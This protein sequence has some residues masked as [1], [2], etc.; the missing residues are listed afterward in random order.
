M[1]SAKQN[2]SIARKERLKGELQGL[3]ASLAGVSDSE[4]D[5]NVSFMELGLDSLFLTQACQSLQKKYSQRITFR[6]LMGDLSSIHAL[7]IFLDGKLPV[8]TAPAA[9]LAPSDA[10]VTQPAAARSVAGAEAERGLAGDALLER[11]VNQQMAIMQQ[12]LELLRGRSGRAAAQ[13]S[14]AVARPAALPSVSPSQGKTMGHGHTADLKRYGP[15]K[16]IEIGP[17]GGLT[18]LQ[19]RSLATL[20]ERYNRRTPGSKAY[21]QQ[22]RSYFCDPRAAGN[23]R[24]QWKEMVY[25]IVCARSKAGKIWDIDGNEYVDVTLGFGANYFGHAPDFVVAALEEQIKKGFEIGPQSPLAGEAAQMLCRMTGMDRATF[26]NTGSEAVMAA[27]RVARTVTARDKVVYFAGDYHGIF[28]EVLARA[29]TVDGQQGA[30]PIAPG[31]PP[32]PNMIVLEYGNPASL[33]TIRGRADEIAAVLVE[34]VQS[35]HPELQPRE[36]LHLLRK[37]TEEKE[38]ALVFDEVVTGFRAAPGGAQEYFGVQADLATY[39]KVIGGGMPIG[40]LAGKRRYMDALDGGMWSFGDNSYPEVGVTFFAG[41]FVRH[42]LT[43]AAVYATLKHLEAAGPE[44]QK[45][46]TERT[47]GLVK[48]IND[49]CVSVGVPIRLQSF[50]SVFFY[51]FHPDLKYGSILFYHL[52]DRGVHIWEGRVGQI[53]TA[54]TDEDLDKV[55]AA[56]K[57]SVEEMQAGGFLPKP[58]PTAASGVLAVNALSPSREVAA[59]GQNAAVPLTEAQKEIWIAAQMGSDANCA[60]NESC[61]L[62]LAGSLD[63]AKLHQAL[64]QLVQRHDAFRARFSPAGDYQEFLDRVDLP[65]PTVDFSGLEEQERRRRIAAHIAKDM[66]TP[67][68]LVSGP[69]VR[70][71]LLK[72]SAQEHQLVFTTHHAVCD[73]WSFGVVFHELAQIYTALVTGVSHDLPSA[74]QFRNYALQC[75]AQQATEE[76]REAESFWVQQ[77]QGGPIPILDL[78]YDRPRPSLKTYAGSLAVRRCNRQVFDQF[79]KASGQIGNTVFGTLFAAFYTL[80]H[81]LS[82]QEDLVVGIPAAGQALV[83]ANDLVGHCLNFLPTRI[84]IA[85]SVPFAEYATQ[86]KS[87]V[88]DAYDHQNYTYGTLIRK[89]RI[90]RD[91]SRLPLLSVLFNIDKRGLDKIKFQGLSAEIVTNAKQFVNFDLFVNLVQGEQDLE[92]ECEYNTDLFDAATVERW[93][94]HFENLL[95]AIIASPRA[96]LGQLSLWSD[97]ERSRHLVEWNR[98]EQTFSGPQTIHELFELQVERTP[99]AVAAVWQGRTMTYREL[100][101][102]AN[103]HAKKLR[104]LGAG[105]DRYVALFVERGFDLLVGVLAILKSGAAY[106]PLDPGYPQERINFY[107]EDSRASILLTQRKLV[108]KLRLP[109]LQVVAVDDP[110]V[111]P[112]PTNLGSSSSSTHVAYVIYTSGSTGRPKGVAIEHRN[113][114]N[115][116]YWGRQSFSAAELAGVLASTSVCFD[117]SIFEL[118]VTLS[119]GGAVVM[120]ENALQVASMPASD[121]DRITLINTVPSAIAALLQAN[122]IPQSVQVV[123]LAGEMLTMQLVDQLYSGSSVK[124]VYD[125]YG[126]TETTTYSTWTL[127]QSGEPATVGRPLPNT[128]IYLVDRSLQPVPI[129]VPGEVLIGGLGVARGYLG[130]PELTAERFIQD[131]FQPGTPGRLYRTGDLARYRLDGN[132]ELLGRL[133]HQV[134]LRGFRI[135]LGEIETLLATHPQV[136]ESVVV[137]REDAADQK[138]LVAYVGTQ[139]K[140]ESSPGPASN[141]ATPGVAPLSDAL[142]QLAAAKLPDY[143]VPSA[144]VVLDTLPRTLNGKIDRKALPAPQGGSARPRKEFVAPRN[145]AESKLAGIWQEILGLDRVGVLDSFFELGG[146]SLLSFRVC[147]RAKQVGLS[148]T[149]RMFFEH[150]TISDLI[151]ASTRTGSSSVEELS[152]AITRVSREARRQRLPTERDR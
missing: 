132:L 59:S 7:A 92:M 103:A 35:R 29:G 138:R 69:V 23:F 6:Q 58:E 90:E 133:D 145:E 146:D 2:G 38:I 46:T 41:T 75:Q 53:C 14:P 140:P 50:S 47:A 36:F 149:P 151:S 3:F 119:A 63:T 117:L 31:I 61:S 83:D 125:L 113:A 130:R 15:F 128:S 19:E 1:T 123:N 4:L 28:D 18:P 120:A 134:K 55:F 95:A 57:S 121:R 91:P 65:M 94:G 110:A 49:Y 9:P 152:P 54:H 114:A 43:M 80:L 107:L 86:V 108:P 73:G 122:A 88:L 44:L 39:G 150:H 135:E 131:P 70:V 5:P 104:A 12:Q 11:V 27:I 102:L 32:L 82:G 17:K 77:F 129:G 101:S 106:V 66:S 68:D 76:V 20:C 98:T 93:L 30:L 147:N 85:P 112:E 33:E 105:P 52:R 42:P 116:I 37:L 16:G 78:P 67:F 40:V 48:R 89:L 97:S 142:L 22:H 64:Q 24:L 144:I 96:P 139:A 62:K 34:P 72:L 148:L 71:Q 99:H 137:V 45:R 100:N 141:A 10:A 81:R 124:K 56:F 60:Y 25:P 51:D 118:F 13:P 84:K 26:C 8:E 79:K 127:R 136:H 111:L 21:A 109:H 87:A 126:P 143:M 115:F 74:N